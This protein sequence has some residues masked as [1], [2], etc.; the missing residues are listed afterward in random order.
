MR[1]TATDLDLPDLERDM[2]LTRA[3]SDAM[4]RARQQ[5]PLSFEEYLQFLNSLSIDHPARTLSP[6]FDKP[7][8]L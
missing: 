6:P 8:E 3:D 4:W 7:F 5:T 2:P 1:S